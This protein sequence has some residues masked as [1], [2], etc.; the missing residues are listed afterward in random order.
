MLNFLGLCLDNFK[1]VPF[2]KQ[3]FKHFLVLDFEANC[4]N[5]KKIE[6][7]EIIEFPCLLVDAQNFQVV[8]T[9]HKYIKVIDIFA[10][11][12][13][14]TGTCEPFSLILTSS[15]VK[16][17]YEWFVEN[18]ILEHDNSHGAASVSSPS[19]DICLG[20]V[21]EFMPSYC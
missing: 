3:K 13:H 8:D 15:K 19:L 6:P 20:K 9:F 5:G 4:E 12:F 11:Q 10:F 18:L 17:E 21:K 7:Q 16:Y 2:S 1:S 14:D